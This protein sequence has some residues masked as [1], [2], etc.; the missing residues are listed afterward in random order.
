MDVRETGPATR[1]DPHNGTAEIETPNP[2]SAAAALT[3]TGQSRKS[4][5]M[6][7]RCSAESAGCGSA[8]RPT[9]ASNGVLVRVQAYGLRIG[10]ALLPIAV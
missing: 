10:G 4:F 9:G 1:S 2:S 5:L 6:L 8:S 3:K 7:S